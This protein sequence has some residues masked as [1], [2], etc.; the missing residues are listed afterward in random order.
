MILL[1]R[2][3]L[4]DQLLLN[5][6]GDVGTLGPVEVLTRLAVFIPLQPRIL[7]VVETCQ[8]S[9]NDLEGL[10]ALAHTYNLARSH[11]V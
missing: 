3:K 6:L 8:G 1:F 10:A 7:A 4:N 11:T 9:S 2:V 5:G